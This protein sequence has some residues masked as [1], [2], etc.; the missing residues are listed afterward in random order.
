MR[1]AI[2]FIALLPVLTLPVSFADQRTA[3]WEGD[4][5]PCNQRFELLKREPMSLG[6]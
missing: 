2:R 4:F 3:N 1:A 5:S 6:V